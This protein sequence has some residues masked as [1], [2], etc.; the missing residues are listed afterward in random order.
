MPE[1]KITIDGKEILARE[2]DN[3]LEV[4]LA[5]G[6]N[7]PHLCHDPRI[8][9]F[10]SCR[11]CF[12][13][14][15]GPRGPVPACGTAVA[16]GMEVFTDN[17]KL[18]ALRQTALELLISEHCGDCIAPCQLACPAHIDIQGY[19][20]FIN[21]KEYKKAADLIKETMPL[22]SVCGRV[23]PRFCED[24]CRRNLVDE[25]VNICELKR[26]A[27]DFDLDV[28][29]SYKPMVKEDSGKEVAVVGGGP[30]GLSAAYFLA[31]EGHRVT[32]FD[33]GPELGGML[34]YGIPEYRLPKELLDREINL[35][36]GLCKEVRLGA[37]MGRDF[38]T[39][40]LKEK[41]DAV[42]LGLGSQSAQGMGM[43]REDTPGILKGI[44]FLR[45]VAEGKAP[46]LG[47]RVAVVG[48]GNTAMDAARTA[49]RLG[50]EVTVIYRRSRE[51]MPAEPIEIQEAEEEGV[52]FKFLTN[53]TA[54][55]GDECVMGVEC[56]SMELGEPDASGR[57]RPVEIKGS[58]FKME[59]DNVIMAIG[60]TLDKENAESCS[61]DL[62]GKNL[63]ACTHTGATPATGIFAAG[64]AVTGPATVV[65]AVGAAKRA[66]RAINL[67]LQGGDVIPEEEKFNCSMGKLKEID[68]AVFSDKEKIDR[69]HVPH[70]EPDIRKNNFTEYNPGLSE[71]AALKESA[72]CLS[73][74]CQDV[75]ECELRKLSTDYGVRSQRLGTEEK[76][77]EIL[78]N[79][80]YIHQDPN[81]CILCASCVRI[82]GEVQGA[83][84]L[85]LVNRG[86][87]T[88]VRPMLELP[89]K[90]TTCERCGQCISACPTGALSVQTAFGQLAGPF[91]DD[92][93]VESTCLLCGIGC[94]V[95]LHVVAG[96]LNRI[97]SPLRNP[98]NEGSLCL[99]GRFANKELFGEN[100]L[101]KPLVREKD[102]AGSS[103]EMTE[104]SWQE[105][106]DAAA[107]K[108]K[109]IV[110]SHGPESI[111][112]IIGAGFTNEESEL[113]AQ[114]SRALK[115]S[116][117][118]KSIYGHPAE[119]NVSTESN[120]S[121]TDDGTGGGLQPPFPYNKIKESDFI[122]IVDA[123]LSE[124]FPIIAHK[125]R[126]A[127]GNGAKIAVIS[128][129][130]SRFDNEAETVI[131]VS[132]GKREEALRIFLNYLDGGDEQYGFEQAVTGNS[133]MDK[134]ELKTMLKQMPA[135]IRT[136]PA[137]LIDAA[138]DLLKAE[139][140]VIIAA[141]DTL[142]SYE[143]NLLK[144]TL[145]VGLK[146]N[147][148]AAAKTGD[149]ATGISA[150]I[151]AAPKEGNLLILY[152]GANLKGQLAMDI[153]ETSEAGQQQN[154]N[155]AKARII[156]ETEP[157]KIIPLL[158]SET[159][160]VIIT[161]LADEDLKKADIILPAVTFAESK[162]TAINCEGRR[163]QI[164]PAIEPLTGKSNTDLL[165]AL[166][167]S[168]ST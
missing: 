128:Q 90:E 101:L 121:N 139:N 157:D 69:L 60:Q 118:L 98:V 53:P 166:L 154:K 27:G 91:K 92:A 115:G 78:N 22:P 134:P 10:G 11:L 55:L 42:F 153:L 122:L 82:C 89:L 136:N 62:D 163:Q 138:S 142:K 8:K 18:R 87:D 2:G 76:R 165:N 61:L 133:E 93:V 83:N 31:L 86:Y 156:L 95:S 126:K 116:G 43:D 57:R 124:D 77:Y 48:G 71:E 45:D 23:C 30:A 119:L 68:P 24:E 63:D 162:G 3:L 75:F 16:E 167:K 168:L 145:K 5:N 34:R 4:A 73:C 12:V 19:I 44:E 103:S 112:I 144:S 148:N 37:V 64:D 106:I 51:E 161:P 125:A 146:N 129:K 17:E 65:E 120:N 59:L 74:G 102:F 29:N 1:V 41:Y 104:K 114:L 6:I 111:E 151:S 88:V 58:D 21:N 66:A 85:C 33:V 25:P 36:T 49:L 80:P 84:A 117:K 79:N 158:D 20:A 38:T 113:A 164:N 32:L 137:A 39:E 143:L 26:F 141:G 123:D 14:A 99:K 54:V 159:F 155:P 67:Y 140:P 7:V 135:I 149:K 107:E 132:P 47:R 46:E 105:G 9:P 72:R 28:I 50:S 13:E 40:E 35:I 97:T 108:L 81:K 160:T 109:S 100:R 147:L 152:R 110:A 131:P 150:D 127:Y 56:I 94:Q 15:G 52:T 130:S 96:R 70:T